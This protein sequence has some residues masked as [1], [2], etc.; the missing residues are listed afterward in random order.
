M[1]WQKKREKGGKIFTERLDKPR[2]VCYNNIVKDTRA[3]RKDAYAFFWEKE[4]KL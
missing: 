2:C 3:A 1:F 4:Q